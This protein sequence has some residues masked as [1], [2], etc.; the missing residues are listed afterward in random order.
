MII[1]SRSNERV[2][3]IRALRDRRERDQ[4]GT[5]FAEGA[6]LLDAA[7]RHG[8]EIEQIVVAPERLSGDEMLLL[9]R[10]SRRHR[11]LLE[12][13]GPVF[14]SLSFR[15]EGAAL[16]AVVRQR[17]ETLTDETRGRRC[18]V[19][20]HDIQHPGNLGTIIRT[21]D[22][23]GGDGVIIS[24]R[25]TDPYH[26]IAVRGSLGAVFSQRLVRASHADFERW[27][28]R[29]G[30]FV[31]GTSPE[32]QQD[33]REVEYRPPV[34][35]IGGNERTGISD[36]Q[37]A[38]CDAVVRIPMAGAVESLNLSVATALVLYE[39]FR[40]AEAAQQDATDGQ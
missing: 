15:E 40:R 29:S 19:L 7:R 28:P 32:G 16:G 36:A 9:E 12:V 3:Q 23:I 37:I 24:G 25:S 22:A 4:T 13:S 2:K 35:L 20:L 18:W 33:Y 30:A 38:L 11:D 8:G 27:L 26:P 1:T 17:W 5:F 10:L 21:C 34:V 6:R 31:V 14:D 39:V